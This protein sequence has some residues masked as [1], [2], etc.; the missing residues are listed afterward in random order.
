MI[1]NIIVFKDFKFNLLGLK[2]KILDLENLIFFNNV[3]LKL[4]SK[5]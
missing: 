1:D 3:V 5:F 4:K 2:K